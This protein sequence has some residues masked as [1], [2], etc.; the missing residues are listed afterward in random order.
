MKGRLAVV[1]LAG[2]LASSVSSRARADGDPRFA[3]DRLEPSERGSDWLVNESL[4]LRGKLRPSFGYVVTY[5]RKDYVVRGPT[6]DV[7]PVR[8]VVL[9]HVGGSLVVLDRFRVALDLPLEPYANGETA[10]G[11]PGPA[12]GEGIGDLRVSADVRVFGQYGGPMTG[13]LGLSLWAPTGQQSQWT[14]DGVL[15]ARP[16]AMLSGE[17]G[18]LVW[19]GQVGL[20]FRERSEAT[21]A[22]AVGLRVAPGLVVGPELFAATTFEGAFSKAG[23]PVEALFGAHWLVQGTARVSGGLGAGLGE[24]IGAPSF[25]AT[26]AIEWA[27][28]IRKPEP[29][30]VGPP[31]A[32]DRA[33]RARTDRDRDGIRDVVDACPDVLGVRT[34]DP[35]TNGCPPDADSDGVDDLADAC[36]TV[37]GIDSSDPALRGCPDR[38]RDHDGVD[39]ERDACPDAPGPSDVDPRR[40]GCPKAFVRGARVETLDPVAF[41]E[42][43][44]TIEPTA[45][46]E[47]LLT[48]LLGVVLK[49]PETSKIRIEGHTDNRGDAAAL[50]KLGLARAA[51]VARWLVEH[52][53]AEA[54]LSSSGVGPDRP[55]AT[56][57]T[58]VGRKA[59]SRL[60]IHLDYSGAQLR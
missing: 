46:N 54:R 13:A 15:R 6:G 38:D 11:V 28:D 22:G 26:F 39:D 49:L 41:K 19:A 14:S 33:S 45:E 40:S 5:A 51:A 25:R 1:V 37:P 23:T 56:N 24:G 12:R 36:P 9:L 17:L 53:I 16:R 4:D 3:V 47:A 58:E 43:S 21:A 29:P 20:S 27:P 57:E 32:V 42:R 10:S 7:A 2:L 44:A 30:V 34:D 18:V 35:A 31:A 48:A 52:G 55:I 60:E 50:R 8:D 59:N